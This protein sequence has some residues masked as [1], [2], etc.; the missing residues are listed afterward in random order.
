MTRSL[1]FVA[2]VAVLACACKQQENAPPP[3]PTAPTVQEAEAFA[4][5]FAKKMAPCDT[6]SV[7]RAFLPEVMVARAVSGRSISRTQV[8]QLER[9][10]DGKIGTMLC[11]N[12][13]ADSYTYLRTQMV[14]GTPRP[15]FR[16]LGD[17]GV[18]YHELELDKRG[19]EIKIADLYIYM[20]GE[21]LSDTF[22]NLIDTLMASPDM[23]GSSLTM[24][25]IRQLMA[26]GDYASARQEL[27]SLP[28]KLRQSKPMML[29]DVQLTSELDNEAEYG[30]AIDAYAKAFPNDP[31]LDLV[32][33][34]GTLMKKKYAET[35]AILDRLDKRLG[36]DPYLDVLR[37]GAL[38][39]SGKLEDAV[40]AAQKATTREPTLEPAWW[41][42]LTTQSAAKHYGD[43]LKTLETLRDKF[44][45][46]T[47]AAS[48]RADERFIKLAASKEYAAWIKGAPAP[49]P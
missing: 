10:L 5:D 43:A 48:L 24:T 7:D 49:R 26:S 44:G 27:Q 1:I 42:L 31:S 18:N 20:T 21:R 14:D 40:T 23:M 45:A 15:L 6:A 47:D 41:Q 35:L 19:G 38:S 25:R 34:D 11:T 8:S 30:K 16:V 2:A 39:E 29:M 22:A 33:V 4:K 9:E 13:K 37:A 46:K 17:A 36:G 3:K 12:M 28:S 32:Q